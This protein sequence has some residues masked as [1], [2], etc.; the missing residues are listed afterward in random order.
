LGEEYHLPRW[1][2]Y[3]AGESGREC[4]ER[5]GRN[6]QGISIAGSDRRQALA[7]VVGVRNACWARTHG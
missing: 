4:N 2:R 6:D 1:K 3:A 5:D 7:I